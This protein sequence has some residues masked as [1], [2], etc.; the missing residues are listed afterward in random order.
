MSERNI[1]LLY[2]SLSLEQKQL[3]DEK[4]TELL[5]KQGMEPDR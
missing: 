4:I 3:V 5:E 1:S 2:A